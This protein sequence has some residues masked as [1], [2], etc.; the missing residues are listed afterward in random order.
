MKTRILED[1]SFGGNYTEEFLLLNNDN[2]VNGQLISEWILTEIT[3]N[4]DLVKPIWDGENWNEGANIEEI[5]EFNRKSIP[6]VVSQRQLRTQL[7]LNGFDL[8]DI[9]IAIDELTE[10][11][12]SIAQIAWDYAITF[13][14]N[15]PLLVVVGQMLGLSESDIDTIFLNAS[16]L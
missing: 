3:P 13:E 6:K 11:N 12:K 8:N 9:Q 14:R 1:N 7:V 10:P 2:V 5:N 15:S 16:K 4:L